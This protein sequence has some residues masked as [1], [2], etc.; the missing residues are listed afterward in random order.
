M[1]LLGSWVF[2][3][4]PGPAPGYSAQLVLGL[5]AVAAALLVVLAAAAVLPL[6]SPTPASAGVGL[7]AR[8]LH[9]R[10]PRLL[11]PA[12]AGRP[13]PRAPSASPAVVLALR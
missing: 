10:L 11:D 6:P 7:A 13:R 8:A 3:A 5:A 2:A 9:R 12:A 4:L 1:L